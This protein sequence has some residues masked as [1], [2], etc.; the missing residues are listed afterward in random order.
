MNQPMLIVLLY[1]VKKT[2]ARIFDFFFFFLKCMNIEKKTYL[3]RILL[4]STFSEWLNSNLV[5]K[6][7]LT[8]WNWIKLPNTN[9][10]TH[11]YIIFN[12]INLNYGNSASKFIPGMD[13]KRRIFH[14]V[15]KRKARYF[16]F[17]QWW[18][19]NQRRKTISPLQLLTSLKIIFLLFLDHN[20]P[21][22]ASKPNCLRCF[23]W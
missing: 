18:C 12:W 14:Y 4:K 2:R 21:K 6:I 1:Y 13:S 7:A 10:D 5:E 19:L 17:T 8:Q 23:N 11:T 15:L 20:I 3:I 16:I 9:G 22:Y